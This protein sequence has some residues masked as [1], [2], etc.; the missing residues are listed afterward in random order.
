MTGWRMYGPSGLCTFSV[1][2]IIGVYILHIND[3]LALCTVYT[4]S[5]F[6]APIYEVI[7]F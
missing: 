1:L 5:L 4:W 7:Y 2:M 6:A 3:I